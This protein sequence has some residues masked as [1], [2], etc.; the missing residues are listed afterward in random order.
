MA[1]QDEIA[2][3]GMPENFAAMLAGAAEKRKTNLRLAVRGRA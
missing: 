3:L 2:E 1:I